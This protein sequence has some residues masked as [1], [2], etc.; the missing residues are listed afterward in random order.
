MSNPNDQDVYQ[1]SK[2]HQQGPGAPPPSGGVPPYGPGP[3]GFPPQGGPPQGNV[4]YYPIFQRQRSFL[5][6]LIL[7]LGGL[8]VLGFFS[9]LF[10]GAMFSV[11]VT[12][13]Q[14]ASLQIEDAKPPEKFVSGN[15]NSKKKIIIMTISGTILGKEDGFVKK[16]IDAITSDP[17]VKAIV[18]RINSPGG[19]VTGSDYYLEHLKR[20]KEETE[21]PIVVSMGSLATSGGY[22]VAM[23]GDVLFAEPTTWTGSIGV[24]SPMYNLSELCEK[25]GVSSDPIVSGPHKAMGNVTKPMSEEEKKIWQ[26]LVDDSFARFKSVIREGRSHFEENP[27]ELDALATGQVYTANQAL[28]L[29]LVDEIGFVEA[30]IERARDLAGL[31]ENDSKVVK[32]TPVKGLVEAL[33]ESKS[34]P[35]AVQ[36]RVFDAM[37]S[38][39]LY[40]MMPGAFPDNREK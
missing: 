11:V 27:D 15:R 22:Y 14:E 12:S 20:M 36:S 28:E 2:E 8:C 5:G 6:T 35:A 1:I 39:Q 9:V 40:Y 7:T 34:D 16:Q 17:E 32:F 18:L 19:T 13:L 38:P 33:L 10:L 21:V 26:G 4:V 29:K 24:F 31:T 23:V 30:A 25:I 3:G 37:S